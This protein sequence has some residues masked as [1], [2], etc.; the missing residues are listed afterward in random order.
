MLS[1]AIVP[2]HLFVEVYD[3]SRFE[4]EHTSLDRL[5]VWRACRLGT[6]STASAGAPG[7]GAAICC[8][9]RQSSRRSQTIRGPKAE[10]GDTPPGNDPGNHEVFRR[11]PGGGAGKEGSG[12]S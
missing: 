5:V 11:N 3:A 1:K 9:P 2:R 7:P 4:V 10:T 12:I 6:C 8:L